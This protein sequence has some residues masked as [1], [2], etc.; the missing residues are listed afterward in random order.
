[1]LHGKVSQQQ[2]MFQ[3]PAKTE[4]KFNIQ[5]QLTNFINTQNNRTL[6]LHKLKEN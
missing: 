5:I 3:K 1:M 6:S 4:F 2:A